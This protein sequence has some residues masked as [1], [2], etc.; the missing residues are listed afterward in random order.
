MSQ[1]QKVYTPKHYSMVVK[2]N[3]KFRIRFSNFHIIAY[4]FEHCQYEIYT[5]KLVFF[6]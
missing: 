4:V 5:E 1:S 3:L 6:K 2:G